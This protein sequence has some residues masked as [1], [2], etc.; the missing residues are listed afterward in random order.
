M[1]RKHIYKSNKYS[2]MICRIFQKQRH[3][4]KIKTVKFLFLLCIVL[5]RSQLDNSVSTKLVNSLSTKKQKTKFSS[6][7][8]SKNLSP[9]C[10]ILRIQKKKNWRADSV[11]VDELAQSEPPHLDLL[12]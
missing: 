9:N 7:S 4:R 6:A 3:N 10:I 8:F 2:S 1:R 12:G 5:I 11:D